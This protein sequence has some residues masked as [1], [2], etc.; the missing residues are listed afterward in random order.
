MKNVLSRLDELGI[1]YEFDEH[2]AVFTIEEIIALGLNKKGMRN[3][4]KK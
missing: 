1:S 2:E 3:L 4:N